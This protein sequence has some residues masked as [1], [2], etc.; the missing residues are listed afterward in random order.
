MDSGRPARS[1]PARQPAFD[2]LRPW[3]R[4]TRY[5][6]TRALVGAIVRLYLRPRVVGL[7]RNPAGPY[8][9]CFNH[10]SWADPFILVALWPARPRVYVFGPREED[11][12]VGRRNFL[13]RWL[14]TSVPFRPVKDDLLATTKR[15]VAILSAG[16]VLAIAG[17]G[18]LSEEE[19]LVLPL[20]D[21]AA[22]LALR[23]RVPLV[24]V[25]IVGTRWLRFGKV[26]EARLGPPIETGGRRADRKTVDELTEALHEALKDLV[27]DHPT[28]GPPG[29]FGRWLTDVFADRPWRQAAPGSAPVAA[30]DRIAGDAPTGGDPEVR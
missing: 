20:N 7:D 14:G 28:E 11:M 3:R 4:S 29:R 6:L 16:H 25:G 9:L 24:P 1:G 30:P 18:R 13:I 23:G 27:R 17:E 21:G 10:L 2:T 19:G 8:V 26:V 22:F 5:R 15:A 12:D